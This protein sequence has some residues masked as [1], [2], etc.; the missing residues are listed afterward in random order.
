MSLVFKFKTLP[1]VGCGVGTRHNLKQISLSVLKLLDIFVRNTELRTRQRIR[2]HNRLAFGKGCTHSFLGHVVVAKEVYDAHVVL[3]AYAFRHVARAHRRF[4]AHSGVERRNHR[5]FVES[6][7][8]LRLHNCRCC[9]VCFYDGT[10]IEVGHFEKANLAF[11]A[12]FKL[13]EI[14][15]ALLSGVGMN[16]NLSCVGSSFAEVFCHVYWQ[17]A[18]RR[19]QPLYLIKCRAILHQVIGVHAHGGFNYLEVVGVA[20]CLWIAVDNGRHPLEH[21]RLSRN[22]IYQCAIVGVH[23]TVSERIHPHWR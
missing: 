21:G 12:V 7:C 15:T 9:I 23:A 16:R 14:E 10:F 22:H 1:G 18:L 3:E 2:A 13:Y 11:A 6:I 8:R 4:P 19:S 5:Q 17:D 20:A